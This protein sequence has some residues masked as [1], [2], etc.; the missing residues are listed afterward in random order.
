[1]RTITSLKKA[2]AYFQEGT[3]KET[4]KDSKGRE[5]KKCIPPVGFHRMNVSYADH[6]AITFNYHSWQYRDYVHIL[7]MMPVHKVIVYYE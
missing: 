2:I 7:T 1:M 5:Y 4:I 6:P 3:R